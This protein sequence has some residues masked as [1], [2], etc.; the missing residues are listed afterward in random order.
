MSKKNQH[1][2]IKPV[3]WEGRDELNLAEF[4]I[5]LLASRPDRSLKTL[6]FEDKI[7]TAAVRAGSR[8]V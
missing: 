5:A 6:H 4:P 3:P 8:G 2:Q 7:G 1:P